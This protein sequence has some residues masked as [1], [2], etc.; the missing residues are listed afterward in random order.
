MLVFS[1]RFFSLP[2]WASD[3]VCVSKKEKSIVK[4]KNLCICGCDKQLLQ[5]TI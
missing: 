1:I 4:D 5:E 2:F 3:V